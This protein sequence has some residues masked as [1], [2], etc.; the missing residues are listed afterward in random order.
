MAGRAVAPWAWVPTAFFAAL[1][2]EWSPPPPRSSVS[3]NNGCFVFSA[4]F[5]Q[6][7]MFVCV[8]VTVC[9]CSCVL[10]CMCSC[11]FMSA[12]VCRLL[13]LSS[14]SS[15]VP[16]LLFSH[17]TP[18]PPRR[19]LGTQID[20]GLSGK[21]QRRARTRTAEKEAE[22]ATATAAGVAA[23]AG[24]GVAAAAATAAATSV[25]TATPARLPS[26]RT[27][28][29]RPRHQHQAAMIWRRRCFAGESL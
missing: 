9:L 10:P 17:P 6:G 14:L 1:V 23:E 29:V 19:V 12:C 28:G 25:A 3:M 5:T 27:K 11:V 22:A 7:Q 13:T 26:R 4:N 16:R 20:C 2:L 21:F 8:C 15:C 24:A 18:A